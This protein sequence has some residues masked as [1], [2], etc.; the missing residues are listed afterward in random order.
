MRIEGSAPC[1]SAE[2]RGELIYI[3]LSTED[4]EG[5]GKLLTAFVRGGRGG[6]RRAS[7]TFCPRR[8]RRGTENFLR[9]LSTEVTEGH[10]ELLTAFVRG[11]QGGTENFLLLLSTEDT[12]GTE[13]FLLLLSTEDTKGHGELPTAFVRGGQGGTENFLLLLSAEDRGGTE[14]SCFFCPRRI[15]GSFEGAR[16]LVGG[17]SWVNQVI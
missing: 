10:G 17:S 14:T 6:A 15:E 8:T 1:L 13:N 5:H 16:G 7:Y 12:E 11:G 4:T 3:F 2:G 9:L